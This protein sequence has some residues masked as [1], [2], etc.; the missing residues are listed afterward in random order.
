MLDFL[1]R[2]DAQATELGRTDVDLCSVHPQHGRIR[3]NYCVTLVRAPVTVSSLFAERIV[4]ANTTAY[5]TQIAPRTRVSTAFQAG[6]PKGERYPYAMAESSPTISDLLRSQ[7]ITHAEVDAAVDA[8]LDGRLRAPF[9]FSE[10]WNLDLA[11]AVYGQVNVKRALESP[12][13]TVGVQ[14]AMV[15]TAILLARPE[16]T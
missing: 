12:T 15:R 16:K 2:F 10:G 3:E 4:F 5:R 8:L 11:E 9:R 14:R 13:A 1:E 6:R 7:T